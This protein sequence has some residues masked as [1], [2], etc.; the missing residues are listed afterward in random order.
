MESNSGAKTKRRNRVYIFGM[1]GLSGSIESLLGKHSADTVNNISQS[2]D[3][4]AG[5]SRSHGSD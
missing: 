4:V 3:C 1:W 2:C 5:V